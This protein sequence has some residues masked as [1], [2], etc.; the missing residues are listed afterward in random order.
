M[1]EKSKGDGG[2]AGLSRLLEI[3]MM[4]KGPMVVAIVFSVA[5]AAASFVPYAAIYLVIREVLSVYPDVSALDAQAVLLYA[6]LALAGVFANIVLYMVSVALSHIAAYGTLDQLK[7]NVP[8]AAMCGSATDTMDST[9]VADT[10]P[11]ARAA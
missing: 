7:V 1:R 6:A 4:K 9:M 8:Y 5:S 10:P 3:A 2:N 11:S